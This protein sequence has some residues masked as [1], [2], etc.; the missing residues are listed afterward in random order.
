MNVSIRKS[1]LNDLPFLEKIEKSCFPE[2]QQS[3][4]RSLRLSLQSPAQQVWIAE[5]KEKR[6]I[7][8]VGSLILNLY[9]HTLRIYSIGVLPEY[10]SEGIGLML[11]AQVKHVAISKGFDKLSLEAL[12]T[13]TK[14][15]DWY[16][17]AGFVI[18]EELPNYYSDGIH[19]QRMIL[20]LFDPKERN[21]ITNIIVVDNPKKWKLEIEG[22]R[23]ISSKSYLSENEF[24]SLKNGRIFNLSNSYR[25][26]SIG[27]YVSLLASARE[28]RAIPNVT[29]IRDF[30][31]VS[32]IRT[33]AQ[34]IDD[35][36]QKTL[37]KETQNQI[38]F[39]IYFGQTID[40]NYKVLGH[41]LYRLFET[42]LMHVQ[43]NKT[44]RWVI[45]RVSPLSL[46]KINNEDFERI[47][48]F[49][50]EYFSRK[51]FQRHRFNNYKYDLAILVNPE[52][53]NPPSNPEALQMFKDAAKKTGF[54]TEFITKDDYDRLT[55]FDALFIRETTSVNNYTYHFSRTAYAE[56][57]VV[58]DDPWS[59]LRCSNKIFLEERMRQNKILTPQTMILTK[60]F[61]RKN[62]FDKLQY[63]M[64]LKQPDSAFSLGVTKVNNPDELA[65][66]L[67]H[68]FKKSD[69]IIAQE[70]VPSEY[71]WR[72]G[73]LDQKPLFACKYFMAK[74][75]WQICNWNGEQEDYF[76]EV[77]T[78][79]V[80][81]VPEPIIKAATKAAALMGDGLYGVDLKMID[82]KAYVIEV[83]DNPN[84]D[85]GLEDM[86]L[87]EKLYLKIMQSIYNRIEMS[88]NIA[89]FVSVETDL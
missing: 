11:M 3:S 4:R 50:R 55:E 65:H 54:Y 49:A 85:A 42:P 1:T 67:N 69:L 27:Y 21:G 61:I 76:G 89:R 24:Q 80:E 66:S 83:N 35:L 5:V 63:P 16:Q 18:T 44:D 88:R 39:N 33:I 53:K 31:N 43:F 13:N 46:D 74:D 7:T 87:K 19:A 62:G 81:D 25:Y 59:I 60:D 40:K 51:R 15:I 9:Q 52:E 57:L 48:H 82:G 17:K 38:S 6:K 2:F 8:P 36:L 12:S 79:L 84:V 34:D 72:I 78:M 86:V 20:N 41:N 56:G 28:H 45:Q 29:T 32:I 26:Q 14:L 68:L 77:E 22:L 73:M 75:H 37:E 30:R 71:D 23:V 58:I 47:Q 64:V 70:F 10:Q